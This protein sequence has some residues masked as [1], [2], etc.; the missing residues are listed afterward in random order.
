MRFVSK[1]EEATECG[2]FSEI[3]K[4]KVCVIERNCLERTT[5]FD[6]RETRQSLQLTSK[7]NQNMRTRTVRLRIH[8]PAA[9]A[10]LIVLSN[11][12]TSFLSLSSI[13]VQTM[14]DCGNELDAASLTHAV[15]RTAIWNDQSIRIFSHKSPASRLLR[16]RLTCFISYLMKWNGCLT[17]STLLTL[18]DHSFGRCSCF[19]FGDVTLQSCMKHIPEKSKT[20][21]FVHSPRGTFY[22]VGKWRCEWKLGRSCVRRATERRKVCRGQF[23]QTKPHL[24][25]FGEIAVNRTRAIPNLTMGQW[26]LVEMAVQIWT[27]YYCILP[28]FWGARLSERHESLGPNA[29][30]GNNEARLKPTTGWGFSLKR[31]TVNE[32]KGTK[33]SLRSRPNDL[34]IADNM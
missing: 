26:W 17:V 11:L 2:I 25:R 6:F 10:T 33:S 4:V 9:T 32:M 8:G 24:L 19:T 3:Q 30:D 21:N 7:L 20:Q 13:P 18:Y 27:K 16:L 22:G 29:V 34:H 1:F 12:R 23:S 5:D 31:G 14:E 15:L 28:K